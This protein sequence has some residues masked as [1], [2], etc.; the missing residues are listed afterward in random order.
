[1]YSAGSATT[2]IQFTFQRNRGRPGPRQCRYCIF[3]QYVQGRKEFKYRHKCVGAAAGLDHPAADVGVST[4]HRG[5]H[6]EFGA[7]TAATDAAEDGAAPMAASVPLKDKACQ[8]DCSPSPALTAVHCES[9]LM[10]EESLVRVQTG[11]RGH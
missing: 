5:L 2:G 11:C 10:L 1:M 6:L 3:V 4:G 7:G 8:I 9:V